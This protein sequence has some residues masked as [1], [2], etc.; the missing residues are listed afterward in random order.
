[1][2]TTASQDG[3]DDQSELLDAEPAIEESNATPAA[4]APEVADATSRINRDLQL[5]LV[6]LREGLARADVDGARQ[7]LARAT[8]AR[9]AIK[10]VYFTNDERIANDQVRRAF[11]AAQGALRKAEADA[12]ALQ[13][14]IDRV[15]GLLNAERA[16]EDANAGLDAAV[17]RVAEATH[18]V[19]TAQSALNKVNALIEAEERAL[20]T[21]LNDS[22]AQI[23]AAVKTGGDASVA[24]NASREKITALKMARSAAQG[25][26]SDAAKLLKAAR[27]DEGKAR[28][29]V[30]LAR[31]RI[32]ERSLQEARGVYVEALAAHLAAHWRAHGQEFRDA[33]PHP[34]A[35]QRAIA[36]AAAA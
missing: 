14:E 24:P 22:A 12:R 23:L 28:D 34:E 19:D 32:T 36:I 8:A 30:C 9:D 13:V 5:T 18:Q 27:D 16:V 21:S 11:K 29:T 7:R 6:D 3:I 1:M 25:E 33:D 20:S 26:L 31:A 17:Q 4:D 10:D 2:T 35:T 15:E